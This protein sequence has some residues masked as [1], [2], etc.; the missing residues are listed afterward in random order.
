M[1]N[2]VWEKAYKGPFGKEEAWQLAKELTETADPSKNLIYTARAL[3]SEDGWHVY[4]LTDKSGQGNPAKFL[5]LGPWGYSMTMNNFYVVLRET[6]KGAVIHDIGSKCVRP[7]DY[8]AGYEVP[9]ITVNNINFKEYRVL[10]NAD[11]TFKGTCGH[12]RT[13]TLEIVDPTK[14]H[15]FNHCD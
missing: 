2:L 5:K 12:S 11:G 3:R 7:A 9:D 4:V 13:H 15:Y 10:K 6:P 8:L 14:E 1:Q